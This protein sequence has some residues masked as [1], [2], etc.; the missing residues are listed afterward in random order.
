M[1]QNGVSLSESVVHAPIANQALY[2]YRSKMGM[3]PSAEFLVKMD[4]FDQSWIPTTTITNGPVA[5]T[6]GPWQGAIIDSGATVAV[7]TT[8]ALGANGVLTLADATASEGAAFY[9]QKSLQ[10]TVG[11]RFF[12][13]CRVRTD[14]VSDN[15]VQFGLS[16][17]T[18]V[19]NPEDLYNTTSANV[20]AFGL[21]DGSAFPTLLADKANAGTAAIAQTVKPMVVNTW[22]ILGLYYDGAT[23]LKAYIDGYQVISTAVT[24]PTGV[25]LAPFISHVN[26]DGA[27]GAVV[28]VDYVRW[29]SQR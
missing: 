25:A 10:L 20:A 11:K 26:G 7:N 12:M 5:N 17:L 18:A 8:A 9:G 23:S 13:E 16:D 19:T 29:V 15:A 4:D 3:I 21:L 24:I 14:D 27:G 2:A 1:A 22:H 28:L 6:P